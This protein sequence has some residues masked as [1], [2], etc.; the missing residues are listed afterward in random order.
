MVLN[1]PRVS[2]IVCF[3]TVDPS[4]WRRRENKIGAFLGDLHVHRLVADRMGF[5]R[6]SSSN[7][8]WGSYI[9]CLAIVKF[10][11]FDRC[12]LVHARRGDILLIF[13]AAAVVVV[14]DG[15]ALVRQQQGTGVLER[16]AMI[17]HRPTGFHYFH[18]SLD[19]V[20]HPDESQE[21]C[22]SEYRCT[23]GVLLLSTI[24]T[25]HWSHDSR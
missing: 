12:A 14:L 2:R 24:A 13:N 25:T 18:N 3:Y 11:P 5:H 15:E 19:E 10:P 16:V 1:L 6:N 7:D 20:G 17:D 22:N 4:R 21:S 23:E 8:N 9:D